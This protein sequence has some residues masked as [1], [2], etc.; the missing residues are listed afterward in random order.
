MA[1]ALSSATSCRPVPN[2]L[3]ADGYVTAAMRDG[4]F[5]ASRRQR[6]AV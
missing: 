2:F 4:L 3:R 6:L 1:A 5:R